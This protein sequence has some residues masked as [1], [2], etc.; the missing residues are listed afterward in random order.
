M[1]VRG[2][3]NVASLNITTGLGA[4]ELFVDNLTAGKVNI[5]HHG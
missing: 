4:G 5:S 1:Y 3:F 2:G